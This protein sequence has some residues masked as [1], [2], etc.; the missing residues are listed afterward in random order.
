MSEKFTE[1]L[2][3]KRAKENSAKSFSKVRFLQMQ[4][5][6]STRKFSNDILE[7]DSS[8]SLRLLFY[9]SLVSKPL[10]AFKQTLAFF[11]SKSD[12]VQLYVG[13]VFNYLPDQP[14]IF[15]GIAVEY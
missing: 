9:L 6:L 8:W 10:F 2:Q 7:P 12:Q 1:N 14:K 11:F 4:G 15:I 3:A 13:S 5:L